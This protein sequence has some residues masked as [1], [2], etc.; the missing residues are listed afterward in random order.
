M[1]SVKEIYSEYV[2]EHIQKYIYH[3]P[4]LPSFVMTGWT[5]LSIMLISENIENGIY[6]AFH[7]YNLFE[8][9]IS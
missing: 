2:Y 9:M 7:S 1:H 3:G 5:L 6:S 8:T 4:H